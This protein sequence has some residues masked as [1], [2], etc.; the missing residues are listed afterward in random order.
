MSSNRNHIQHQG[1]RYD[2]RHLRDTVITYT[3]P[4]V[5]GKPERTY[6]VEVSFSWHCYT[7][8]V[9]GND[10]P[11]DIMQ[12]SSGEQRCFCPNRYSHSLRLPEIIAD[13]SNRYCQ[14]SGR[15]NFITV[16]FID[17]DGTCLE[18]EIYFNIRKA[19]TGK[20]LRLYIETAFIRTIPDEY[21]NKRKKI[22]F[23]VIL[24]N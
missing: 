15:G 22:G 4:A 7:R 5:P 3:Q 21:K 17:D 18:Y 12:A 9:E 2:V 13:L 20:N 23:P 10:K 1:T 8:S 6:T 19:I 11:A 14:T 16:E 24:S